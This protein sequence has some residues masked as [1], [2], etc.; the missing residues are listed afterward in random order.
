MVTGS[1][2]GTRTKILDLARRFWTLPGLEGIAAALFGGT[3][4]GSLRSR[5]L[6][7]HYQFP[8]PSERLVTT[9]DGVTFLADIG[10]L[11]GWSLRFGIRDPGLERFFDLIHPGMTVVDVGSNIGST[12]L[13]AASRVGPEGKVIAFE[14]HSANFA[15]LMGN[16]RLNPDLRVTAYN[17]GLGR[18][19]GKASMIEPVARNPGGFRIASGASG[20]SVVLESLDALAEREDLGLVHVLKIDTEG[21]E[22]EVLRGSQRV[23]RESRPVIFIE[24]S[25]SLLSDQGSSV[26]DVLALLT[27]CGYDVRKAASGEPMGLQTDYRGIHC[28]AI[29]VP[30]GSPPD[31][32]TDG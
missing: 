11:L 30:S 20:T 27:E 29:A 23:L 2:L 32:P 24:L 18:S 9:D 28:D 8:Q 6:P 7:N 15:A 13:P 25:E 14:P 4:L 22:H 10:T 19:S 1:T 12:V 17:L 21:F 3:H 31:A 5:F 26:V 16:L